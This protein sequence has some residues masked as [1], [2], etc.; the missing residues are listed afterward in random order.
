MRRAV[1][2]FTLGTFVAGLVL[3][4]VVLHHGDLGEVA[5]S[6]ARLRWPAIALLALVF[7]AGVMAEAASWSCRV[8]RT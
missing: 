2:R 1:R 6:L 5:A 3:V 8:S 4:G 7:A